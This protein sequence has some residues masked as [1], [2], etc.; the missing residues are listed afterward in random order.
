MRS[1]EIKSYHDAMI[2]GNLSSRY[3]SPQSDNPKFKVG[4]IIMAMMDG[5]V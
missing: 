2:L 1:L 3:L 4:D 5:G